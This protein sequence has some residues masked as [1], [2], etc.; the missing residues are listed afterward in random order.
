[1]DVGETNGWKFDH[2]VSAAEIL[3]T[4]RDE[5]PLTPRDPAYRGEVARHWKHADGGPEIGIISSVTKPFCR[6]C[7]RLRLSAD[8]KAFT[9]LFS[10]HGHDL[11]GVL[12]GGLED[13]TVRQVIAGIWQIRD[14][15]YSEARGE[16]DIHPKV[17]MSYLGG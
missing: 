12:R 8:G 13:D 15:R 2:V 11:R 9:C 17:E 10:D 16:G 6:D 4:L 7:Q 5:F 1:M 14:D 3:E